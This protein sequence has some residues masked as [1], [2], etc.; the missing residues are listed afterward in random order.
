MSTH[1]IEVLVK[2]IVGQV[3]PT[4]QVPQMVLPMEASGGSTC[5][6]QKGWILEALNLQ[7]LAEW[8][9]VEQEQ[10]RELLLKWEHLFAHSGLDL[11]KT[12]L[13]KHQVELTPDALQGALLMYTPT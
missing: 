6:S 10:A 11:G 3:T 5:N 12:S 2:A 7:G 13:I 9:E 8:P 1:P 4:S